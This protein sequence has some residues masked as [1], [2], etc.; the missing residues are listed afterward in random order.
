MRTQEAVDF[1]GSKTI[2]ARAI[3]VTPAA[4]GNWGDEVPT[5]REKSIRMAMKERAE[6]LELEA[7]NLR[8][9][10]KKED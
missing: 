5:S 4:V 3:G 8:K 10:A 7:K 2:L 9:H 1:F 6:Q